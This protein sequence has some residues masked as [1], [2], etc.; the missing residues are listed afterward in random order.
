MQLGST[1]MHSN[2]S[3][4]IAK[5]MV[6]EDFKDRINVER[7]AS[8]S[9]HLFTEMPDDGLFVLADCRGRSV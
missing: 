8:H 2:I 6:G 9:I 3:E 1:E 7:Q 4:P 5:K